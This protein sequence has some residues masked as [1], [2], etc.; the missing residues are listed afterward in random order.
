M[1]GWVEFCK[2]TMETTLNYRF[3]IPVQSVTPE[4][5]AAATITT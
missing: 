4:A 5:A 3:G 2:V 1:A